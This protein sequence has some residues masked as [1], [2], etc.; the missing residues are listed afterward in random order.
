MSLVKNTATIGIFTLASRVLG[1]VRDVMMAHYVGAGFAN[2]AFAVA[3]RLPNLFRALFA[4]GAFS[5]AFVPMFNRVVGTAENE[6]RAG[7]PAGTRF[8]E[9]V[10]ADGAMI[11]PPYYGFSGFEG[12]QRHYEVITA[13]SSIGVVVYFSGAA[14]VACITGPAGVDTADQRARGWAEVF[15]SRHPHTD[16]SAYLERADYRVDGGRAAMERLL[17]LPTPPDAVFVANNLMGVGA[18]QALAEHDADVALLILGDLPFGMFPRP[19]SQI[20]SLPARRLGTTAADLLLSRIKGDATPT[21]T[22]VLDAE[23]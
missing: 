18:T 14:L 4:E 11:T 7:L 10:G 17:A 9:D 12:L 16:P 22:V 13:H 21:Q 23:V 15:G 3:W 2:D 5:A 1:F 19:R 8:A 6:G 20:V